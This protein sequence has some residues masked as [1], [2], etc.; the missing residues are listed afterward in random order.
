MSTANE[1]HWLSPREFLYIHGEPL[2]IALKFN[3]YSS[4][5]QQ[6][7]NLYMVS[8]KIDG[9]NMQPFIVKI[10]SISIDYKNLV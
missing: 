5:Y 6:D 7:F 4:P 3:A 8:T 10:V 2:I 9:Y 1:C